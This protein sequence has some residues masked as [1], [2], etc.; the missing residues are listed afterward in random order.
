MASQ[1]LT[2]PHLSQDGLLR[3]TPA[4]AP[5]PVYSSSLREHVILLANQLVV[6]AGEPAMTN[7]VVQALCHALR[8][9]A[10]PTPAPA[11]FVLWMFMEPIALSAPARPSPVALEFSG[12]APH[13]QRFDLFDEQHALSLL[14]ADMMCN[15]KDFAHLCMMTSTVAPPATSTL[16]PAAASLKRRIN[17]DDYAHSFS[18]QDFAT[19]TKK[20]ANGFC[21]FSQLNDDNLAV[22]SA[23]PP[24]MSASDLAQ[25][26]SD[27]HL[28]LTGVGGIC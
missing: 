28:I 6:S 27:W 24:S 15:P 26:E 17:I 8:H 4:E 16:P 12:G 13:I 25:M 7:T 3:V 14:A 1:L 21:C 23:L 18:S 11:H 10:P 2:L 22:R 19:P 20:P 9:E 5:A